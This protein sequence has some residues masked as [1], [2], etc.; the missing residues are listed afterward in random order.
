MKLYRYIDK[1]KG[2]LV[3]LSGG[4]DSVALLHYLVHHGYYC[5]AAHCNFHLRGVES[6][7]DE[8]FVR[9]LCEEMSVP[10]H[11]MQFDTKKYAAERNISIEM[12]ARELRYQW[13]AKL[14]DQLN[15]PCVAVAHHADDAVE[16]FLL[17]LVRGTG[18]KGLCGMKSVQGRI[19]RPLLSY[20]RQD[21]ELYCRAHKLKY[22]TDSTNNSDAYIRNRI[23]HHVVPEFKA[24]NPS[25]LRTMRGNM[26]HL[27]QICALF[28]T[29]VDEFIKK[30]VAD[31]DGQTLI[32]MEHIQ[33]L[34]NPEPYLFE[35]LFEKGFTSDSIHKIAR[36]IDEKRWGRIY[37]SPKY[38]AIVDRYNI[39]VLSRDREVEESEFD[40]EADKTEITTPIHLKLRHIP[41]D[42]NYVISRDHCIAHFDASKIYYPLTLRRWRNGDTFR[43]LGMKGFKKLSDFFV[44]NKLSRSEKEDVWV[45]ESGGEVVWIVGLRIDDRFK[46]TETTTEVLEINYLK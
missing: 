38:R 26:A 7:S 41:I 10:C 44:D 4:A 22:V 11:V 36:C 1:E 12:A 30:A 43:P 40:I 23:R 2:V 5:I 9:S 8:A 29:Q 20:S 34:P 28:N 32:S 14:L 42:S 16:T 37:I 3:A 6:D 17:N 24:I 18:I 15:I 19:V 33:N 31:L 46:I 45:L 13:F 27:N 21:V 25:F 35:I 39:I